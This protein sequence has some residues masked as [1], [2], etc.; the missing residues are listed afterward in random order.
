MGNS[1]HISIQ[2]LFVKDRVDRGNLCI[3]YFPSEYM[4]ANYFT[5]MSQGK[6]FRAIRRI[7]MGYKS[8]TWLAETM[9]S[10]KE[11]VEKA[12][13]ILVDSKENEK[14]VNSNNGRVFKKYVT[15]IM[16][17]VSRKSLR[18]PILLIVKA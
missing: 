18:T 4:L 8:I 9:S 6:V 5:K 12:N 7:I 13:K 16:L 11:R 3:K 1:R 14:S 17:K 10:T 15:L 2:Y